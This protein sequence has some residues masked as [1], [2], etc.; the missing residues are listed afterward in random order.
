MNF[1]LCISRT[2]HAEEEKKRG[3]TNPNVR[4]ILPGP[5]MVENRLECAL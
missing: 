3:H 5:T 1:V 4:T 2:A